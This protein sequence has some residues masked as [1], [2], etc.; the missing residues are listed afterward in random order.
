MRW[1]ISKHARDRYLERVPV[2]MHTNQNTNISILE[3]LRSS[4]DVTN[5][6]FNEVP[7]YIL[8]L[9]ERYNEL[10]LLIMRSSDGIIYLCRKK[11]GTFNTMSIVTCFMEDRYLDNFRNSA[12]SRQD[13]FFKIS[14]IKKKL[15]KS[16]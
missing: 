11:E 1:D 6:I 2:S 12:M 7:R 15:K 16:K 10:G 14:C 3:S 13:V 9:Y 4:K 8:Y 5:K